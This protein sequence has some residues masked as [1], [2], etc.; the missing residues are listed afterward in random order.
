MSDNPNLT[1]CK[2]CDGR[3]YNL[4]AENKPGSSPPEPIKE[5]CLECC[6]T[7]RVEKPKE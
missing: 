6:G 7:G 5:P 1:A 2:A 3:G 4:M